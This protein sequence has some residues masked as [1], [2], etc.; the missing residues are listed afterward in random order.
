MAPL[1]V[2]VHGLDSDL[3]AGSPITARYAWDFG[4]NTP[5]SQFNH[6]V[7]YGG[8]H[9]YDEPG[10]YTITLNIVVENL[11]FTVGTVPPPESQGSWRGVEVSG[12]TT[13]NVTIRNNNFTTLTYNILAYRGATSPPTGVFVL[14]NTSDTVSHYHFWGEGSD[15]TVLGNTVGNSLNGH[16]TRFYAD[17]IFINYNDFNSVPTTTPS[18]WLPTSNSA[19]TDTV[20]TKRFSTRPSPSPLTM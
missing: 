2:N 14:N 9:I 8:A 20:V 6:L 12:P 11:N 3:G 4:D 1:A 7:G 15:H 17:R 19:W 5:S 13:Y 10:T 16:V 18:L